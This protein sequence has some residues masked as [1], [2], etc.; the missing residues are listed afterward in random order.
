MAR[1]RQQLHDLLTALVAPHRVYHQ[2]P[3]SDKLEY[4]CVMYKRDEADTQ[5]ADNIPLRTA[6]G[7][8]VTVI[9]QNPDSLIRDKVALLPM[10]R[11]T[12]HFRTDNL[13]HDVYTLFF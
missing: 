12:R 3:G 10:C 9:D 4:P 13:N 5:Y 1:P 2:E 7:Y 6:V 8:Q 11:F